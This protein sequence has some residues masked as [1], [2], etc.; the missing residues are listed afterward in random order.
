MRVRSA[1]IR[2]AAHPVRPRSARDGAQ[3]MRNRPATTVAA[4]GTAPGDR[5]HAGGD[6]R[7][8]ARRECASNER[9]IVGAYVEA[10]GRCPMLA[11]HRCGGR[12]DFISFAR[13]WDRF[14]RAGRARAATERELSDPG[15]AA[16]RQPRGV[17]RPRARRRDQ[18][19]P[20]AGAQEQAQRAGAARGRSAGRDR[21]AGCA[22]PTLHRAPRDHGARRDRRGAPAR[23][24]TRLSAARL[25]RAP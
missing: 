2:C 21:R 17:R 10:G 12:T 13:S 5:L 16:R 3:P 24:R 15:R 22:A 9:I 14:A 23:A 8:D 11:A 20:C 7:S 4:V 6:P 19:A 25:R 1:G 18:R